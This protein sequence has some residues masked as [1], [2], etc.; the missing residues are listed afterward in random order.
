MHWQQQKHRQPEQLQAYGRHL[1]SMVLTI[2]S[3]E[4]TCMYIKK[5]HFAT[6]HN[7]V[8]HMILTIN[9]DLFLNSINQLVC[10]ME[11]PLFS[12]WQDLNFYRHF[13][14]M[15][16]FKGLITWQVEAVVNVATV[17][18]QSVHCVSK[19]WVSSKLSY[20]SNIFQSMPPQVLCQTWKI[21]LM[22]HISCPLFFYF[23]IFKRW[24]HS[25][26][27]EQWGL[28]EDSKWNQQEF[29]MIY[30]KISAKIVDLNWIPIL[31]PTKQP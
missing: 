24:S 2:S 5:L 19:W 6:K 1:P 16:C 12:V 21:W 28:P 26:R 17:T 3:P 15:L 20:N 8:F 7:Y 22:F 29:S 9:T 11:M 30:Y 25:M 31:P 18:W 14:L 23:E 13:K 27:S 4:V 10:V